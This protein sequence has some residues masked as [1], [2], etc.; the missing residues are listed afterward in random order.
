MKIYNIKIKL[1]WPLLLNE[2]SAIN[3][4]WSNIFA[5]RSL[6]LASNLQI[7]QDLAKSLSFPTLRCVAT[8]Q[9]SLIIFGAMCK[10]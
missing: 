9:E 6:V 2:K 8:G 5:A 10:L 1:F 4:S 7:F 3:L